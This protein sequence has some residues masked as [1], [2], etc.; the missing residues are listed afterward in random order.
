MSYIFTSTVFRPLNI[1]MQDEKELDT[2]RIHLN[3]LF[4]EW[5]RNETY[6]FD[7]Y[8][9]QYPKATSSTFLRCFGVRYLACCSVK[10]KTIWDPKFRP[11]SFTIIFSMANLQMHYYSASNCTTNNKTLMKISNTKAQNTLFV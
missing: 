4:Y 5:N 6:L 7:L 3:A 10:K 2:A 8:H 1:S 9:G 11:Y